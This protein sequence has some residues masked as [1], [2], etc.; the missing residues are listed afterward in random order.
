MKLVSNIF[1][2][3]EKNSRTVIVRSHLGLILLKVNKKH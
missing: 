1:V 2:E 3:W